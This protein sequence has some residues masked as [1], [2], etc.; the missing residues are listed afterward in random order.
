M[1]KPNPARE[2]TLEYTSGWTEIHDLHT[3]KLVN[4]V[5]EST[6]STAVL[7][8]EVSQSNNSIIRL[9]AN[10]ETESWQPSFIYILEKI[11]PD[12]NEQTTIT[13]R[14][15][16]IIDFSVNGDATT[17]AILTQDGRLEILSIEN[18]ETV[19]SFRGD[20][21]FTKCAIVDDG[22]I[23]CAGDEQGNVNFFKVENHLPGH[24]YLIET[25]EKD[26]PQIA[27]DWQFN[28]NNEISDK[29][30]VVEQIP[31]LHN[32]MKEKKSESL[33]SKLFKKN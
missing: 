1:Y 5:N 20:F 14:S 7:K 8:V 2:A 31:D 32:E 15:I 13:N 29:T 4:K 18:G 6:I 11:N 28:K 30:E 12:S 23:V 10:K 3:G 9:I 24:S 27:S 19:A 26:F 21:T 22:R 33:F 17:V 25:N 16:P